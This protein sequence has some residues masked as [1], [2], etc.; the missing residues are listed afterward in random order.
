MSLA[1]RFKNLI[2]IETKSGLASPEPWLFDLFGARPTASKISVTPSSAMTCAA[3]YS[4]VQCISESIAQLPIHV[5]QKNSDGAKDRAPNHP[6][7]K[8][9]AGVANPVTP[10]ARLISEV[11]R[12]ALLY[13]NG[14]FAHIVR[15][16]G[17]PVELIRIDPEIE[18]VSVV[19]GN[20]YMPI[21]S[22]SQKSGQPRVIPRENILHIPSPSLNGRGL[23]YEAREAIGLALGLE[24]C[25][26]R[27]VANNAR[28]GGM[29]S[30]KNASTPEGIKKAGDA[31]KIAN[32]G[33][34]S[35][36]T[37]VIHADASWQQITLS[38]VDAQFQEM[39]AFTVSEVCRFF[40]VPPTMIYELGRATWANT[41]Q[42]DASFLSYSLMPWVRAWQDELMLKLISEDE[43][44][45]FYIEF[46][47]DGFARADLAART[48]AYTTSAGGPWLTPNEVRA[49]ENRPPIIPEG[50]K[51]RPPPN[52]TNV[53][54]TS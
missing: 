35:G 1:S 5:H 50:D 18:P 39:R 3:V 41:E 22:I 44:D 36:G 25:A 10:S 46:N 30:L 14:G 51:L 19:I 45:S 47:V 33:N 21:Y 2:G 20:D 12:D 26:A 48:A 24:Q 28:A 9:V 37:A 6:V 17:R 32:A 13:P 4:A 23:V 38:L 7:E 27:L 8:I 15:A 53:K 49:L 31:W 11:T 34:N 29:I 54:A 42:M 40:R 16:D 52:A 43:R